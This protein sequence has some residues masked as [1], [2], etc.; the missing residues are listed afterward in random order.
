MMLFTFFNLLVAVAR[1]LTLDIHQRR[2]LLDLAAYYMVINSSGIKRYS[3]FYAICGLHIAL[4][5]HRKAS[6]YS[7]TLSQEIVIT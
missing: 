5:L 2:N 7:R 3:T 6:T 1:D 4:L